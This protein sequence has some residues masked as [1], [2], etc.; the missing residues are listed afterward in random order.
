MKIIKYS[1]LILCTS[2]LLKSNVIAETP[3]KKINNFE[4]AL[5]ILISRIK[6]DK[7]Y[8]NLTCLL[9][10]EESQTPDYFE[11]AIEEKHGD[12]CPG[13]PNT[14]PIV[15]RFRVS[16]EGNILRWNVVDGIFVPYK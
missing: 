3:K 6:Q 14:S 10:L 1:G 8:P 12:G 16:P 7:I 4:A 5:Q 2:L 15:D 9:F 13:D 11:V